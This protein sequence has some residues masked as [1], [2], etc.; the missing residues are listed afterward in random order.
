[1]SRFRHEFSISVPTPFELAA[2]AQPHGWYEIPPYHWDGDTRTLSVAVSG[3]RTGVRRLDISQRPTRSRRT[4]RLHLTWRG[5]GRPA[6]TD[7]EREG[8]RLVRWILNLDVDLR[9]FYRLC[10]SHDALRWVERAGAGRLLRGPSVFSDVVSAICGTNIQWKQAVRM[11]HRLCDIAPRAP[12]LPVRRYPTAE[13]LL[14]AG[15]GHL[16]EHARIGYRADSVIRLCEGVRAGSVDLEPV[17]R[18]TLD[19]PAL[20]ALFR[21][22]PGIGPVTAR[23]LGALYGHFDELAVDSLVLTYIGDKYFGGRKPREAEVQKLYA[24]FGP[25]R[26]LAYWFEFLGD[27]DPVTWRGWDRP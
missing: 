14:H 18:G 13:E 19:G 21:S 23:Y 12:G 26:A 20:R 16:R 17:A 7:L 4:R 11:V 10:K 24:P 1:M 27:V 3:P 9:P 5:R 22:L 25:W 15:A 8:E 2:V 6:S